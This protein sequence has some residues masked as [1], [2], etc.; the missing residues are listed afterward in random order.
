MS[1]KRRLKPDTPAHDPLFDIQQAA[2][3]PEC[4]GIL[5]AQAET[6][7]AKRN[8]AQLGAIHPPEND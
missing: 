7:E 2:S 3:M 8:I 4:T 1:R 6:P 5:P